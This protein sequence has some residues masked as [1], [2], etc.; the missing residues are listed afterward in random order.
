MLEFAE[1]YSEILADN[2]LLSPIPITLMVTGI[3]TFLLIAL[4]VRPLEKRIGRIEK[5]ISLGREDTYDEQERTNGNTTDRDFEYLYRNNIK[6]ADMLVNQKGVSS[7]ALDQDEQPRPA[8]G[9]RR[10]LGKQS[11]S[12]RNRINHS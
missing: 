10:P 5:L 6:N 9:L 7:K 1:K 8:D 11:L 2:S 3:I 12:R 4:W